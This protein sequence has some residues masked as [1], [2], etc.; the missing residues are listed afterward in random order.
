MTLVLEYPLG[1]TPLDNNELGGLKP[2]HIT[3]QGELNELEQA[4]I[5]TGIEWL[6]RQKSD[7]LTDEFAVKLH[8]QLFGEVWDWAG[9]FRK[10][11]KNIDFVKPVQIPTE[12][13][14][15]IENARYWADH[16]TY[17]PIEAAVRLH[18]RLVQ[19]HPFPNGNGRHSRIFTDAVLKSVYQ[20]EPIDWTAGQDLGK[21]GDR[22][23]AYIHAL[24]AADGGDFEPLF[25]FVKFKR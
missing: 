17:K 21:I 3:T 5:Q 6:F 19:I 23:Q 10:T 20:K 14:M 8:K 12:L 7:V 1:A 18:H 16:K 9:S 24:K 4:N 25:A 2:K 15:L 22:R 13:R 11:G